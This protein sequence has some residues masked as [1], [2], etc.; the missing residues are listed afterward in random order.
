MSTQ[1]TPRRSFRFTIRAI[2]I[3]VAFCA[4]GLAWFADRAKLQREHVAELEKSKA[5]H[6]Y[7]ITVAGTPGIQL[8]MTLVT[9]PATIKRE[10]VTVPYSV[11]FEAVRAAVWFETLPDGKSGGTGSSYTISFKKDGVRG[12]QCQGANGDKCQCGLHDL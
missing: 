11:K 12:A 7:E 5:T 6:N 2:L 10:I 8:E 4:I 1:I 9:K 3:A